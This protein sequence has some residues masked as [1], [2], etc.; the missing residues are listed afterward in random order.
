MKT[1]L[2][3]KFKIYFIKYFNKIKFL[4][5]NLKMTIYT[6]LCKLLQ[7]VVSAQFPPDLKKGQGAANRKKALLGFPRI[8]ILI[9]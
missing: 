5:L 6:I 7:L 4:N 3:I 2:K 9:F 8:Q 1:N